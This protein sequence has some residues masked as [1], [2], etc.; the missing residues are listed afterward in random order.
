MPSG[1]VLSTA[2]RRGTATAATRSTRG[3]IGADGRVDAVVIDLLV[4]PW[5]WLALVGP[6]PASEGSG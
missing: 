3:S 6:V 1:Y 4:L 5:R 2:C